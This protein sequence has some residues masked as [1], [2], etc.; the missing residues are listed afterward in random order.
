MST[1]TL[2]LIPIPAKVTSRAGSFTLT[3]STQIEANDALRA[4]AELLRDQLRPATGF[5]LPIVTKANGPRIALAL[6]QDLARLGDEGYRLTA[7]ADSV[8][9][10]AARPAGLLHGTLTLREL[11]PPAILRRAVAG[12]VAWSVAGVEIEDTPR[13]SWRGSHLDVGRHFMPKM[14][15][16]KH[17]DLLALHK[18]SVFHWHLTEDQGWRIEIKR[19]PKLTEVGAWRKDSMVAPRA[20]DPAQRKFAGRPHGGYYTQDDVREVV[21]YA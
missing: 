10:A 20:I 8:A 15:V 6:D 14:A 17:I 19:Y 12:K 18:L 2:S 9:I 1:P 7:G 5:P 16:L 13:F 3:T 11:L 4:H 21:R